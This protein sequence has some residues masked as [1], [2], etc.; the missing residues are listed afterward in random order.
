MKYLTGVAVERQTFW[1]AY[2]VNISFQ[3]H[4]LL[5]LGAVLT[6]ALSRT[7]E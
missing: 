2:D 1:Q 3:E 7:E 4:E 6:G 5:H